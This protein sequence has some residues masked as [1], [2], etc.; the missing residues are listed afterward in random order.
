[1]KKKYEKPEL[2][3]EKMEMNLLY[4]WCTPNNNKQYNIAPGICLPLS[5]SDWKNPPLT[6]PPT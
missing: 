6:N 1:M 2:I 4:T 3:S 5:C